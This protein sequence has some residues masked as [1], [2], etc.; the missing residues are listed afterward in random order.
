MN[1]FVHVAFCVYVSVPSVCVF[2]CMF[3]VLEFLKALT[4]D[5]QFWFPGQGHCVK[6]KVTG[7]LTVTD[8]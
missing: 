2:I 1:V 5:V 7:A 6:V 4:L 3:A 8:I